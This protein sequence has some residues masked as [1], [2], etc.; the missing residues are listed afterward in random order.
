MAAAP[1]AT[2]DL[3]ECESE[4]L[5]TLAA[6][7]ESLSKQGM[8]LQAEPI[9][10]ELIVLSTRAGGADHPDTLAAMENLAYNL[11]DQERNG[12][13]EVMARPAHLIRAQ[14]T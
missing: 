13:A 14:R 4:R 1:S 8:H 12:D 3:Q 2:D 10:R 11:L 9:Y 5:T 7:A 6:R